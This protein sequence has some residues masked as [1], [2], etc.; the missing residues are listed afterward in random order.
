MKE[1]KERWLGAV[2]SDA[3]EIL[4]SRCGICHT[5]DVPLAAVSFGWIACWCCS[6]GCAY[7]ARR[8]GER[9]GWD[10]LRE[11]F[12]EEPLVLYGSDHVWIDLEVAS[13]QLCEP[14]SEGD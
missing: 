10:Q 9:W 6:E 2:T 13:I 11:D 1:M 3:H 14:V 12:L 4:R 8:N 7:K 5:P